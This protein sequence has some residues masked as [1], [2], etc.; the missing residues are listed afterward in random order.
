MLGVRLPTAVRSSVS[1][2]LSVVLVPG[3]E[4]SDSAPM[5]SLVS[6][7]NKLPAIAVSVWATPGVRMSKV[8][9]NVGR[10]IFVVNGMG[11]VERTVGDLMGVGS[12]GGTNVNVGVLVGKG[13][14]FVR[15]GTS[16]A[17][18]TRMLFT[19]V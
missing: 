13:S 2:G 12:L 10:T 19:A 8:A 7:M 4:V 3:E 15:V 14:V 18:S 17:T 5:P 1:F 9:V 16:V 11:V 6:V